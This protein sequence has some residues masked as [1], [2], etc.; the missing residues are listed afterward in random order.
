MAF[1]V[2][3]PCVLAKDAEGHTHH[4]YEGDTISWLNDEQTGHFLAENLVEE[5]DGGD[6]PPAKAASKAEWVA[7]AVAQGA[8]EAE[9]EGLTKPELVDLYGG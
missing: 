4:Y 6:Q 3:V 7:F 8:D 2:R 1:A 5:S 9:A